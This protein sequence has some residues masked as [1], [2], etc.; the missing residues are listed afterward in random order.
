MTTGCQPVAGQAPWTDRAACVGPGR[1]ALPSGL[2]G[3]WCSRAGA[4]S[5]PRPRPDTV[6][7]FTESGGMRKPLSVWKPRPAVGSRTLPAEGMGLTIQSVG[8][9]VQDLIFGEKYRLECRLMRRDTRLLSDYVENR[10]VVP[11]CPAGADRMLCRGE[12]E[13]SAVVGR[14]GLSGWRAAISR[15]ADV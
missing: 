7:A 13:C 3:V 4:P 1:T 12:R 8:K 9:C 5:A 10:L 11:A 15:L 6:Y 14:L 2:S